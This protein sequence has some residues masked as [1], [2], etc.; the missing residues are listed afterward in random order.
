[1]TTTALVRIQPE[2]D[3]EI[4]S[5]HAKSL[6]LLDYA[7]KRTI[8]TTNDLQVAT[9]DLSIIANLKKS[10]E[11]K[12]R[13]YV[14]PL[15]EYVKEVNDSFK[16]LAQ[17]IE[18]AEQ[19]TKTKMSACFAEQDRIHREQEGINQKRMEA[20]EAEMRLMGELSESVNLVEV[21]EEAP[22]KIHTDM[23]TVGQRDNWH[24]EVVDFAIVPD[25]YKVIDSAMLTM[26]AKKHHDQK[27]IPGVRFYCEKIIAVTAKKE[28]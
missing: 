18:Q 17:P 23:G 11:G 9:D 2:A 24:W 1:M 8:T 15:Q 13:E 27:P 20:A 5:Y 16:I 7:T 6:K 19:I 14:K 22:K 12:R 25:G 3:I 10:L 21:S 4:K 28:S 26:I